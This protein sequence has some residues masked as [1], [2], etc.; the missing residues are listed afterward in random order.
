MCSSRC[1]NDT[2]EEPFLTGKRQN[3]RTISHIMDS[4]PFTFTTLDRDLP[5]FHLL[6]KIPLWWLQTFVGRTRI[7]KKFT[8]MRK[9]GS[10][11]LYPLSFLSPKPLQIITTA[12]SEINLGPI[13]V[14]LDR[15][16]S[17]FSHIKRHLNPRKQWLN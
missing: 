12:W 6:M 3:T 15:Q 7:R 13:L 9:G 14:V 10:Y 2:L 17:K 8:V 16:A 1:P 4:C 11:L 5:R